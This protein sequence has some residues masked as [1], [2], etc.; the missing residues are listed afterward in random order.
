MEPDIEI[1]IKPQEIIEAVRKMKKEERED[2]VEDLL[3]SVS[4]DYL[5]SIKQAREDYKAGR[6][7]SHDET[8]SS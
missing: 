7:K 1:R 8:F 6:V 3:A 2:F 5:E 4:P